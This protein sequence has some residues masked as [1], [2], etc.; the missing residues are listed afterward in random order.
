[1]TQT[2]KGLNN[3]GNYIGSTVQATDAHSKARDGSD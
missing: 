2:H 3:I 1:M